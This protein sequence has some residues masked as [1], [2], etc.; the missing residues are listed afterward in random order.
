[1]Q[2][3]HIAVTYALY[4]DEGH[5]FARAE[6]KKSFNAVMEIFLAQCLGG[7]YQPIGH[8]FDGS[9]ITVPVGKSEIATL[10]TSSLRE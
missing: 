4:P 9:S 5:G 6:N 2:K 1:M 3:N 8:D 7:S 10:A